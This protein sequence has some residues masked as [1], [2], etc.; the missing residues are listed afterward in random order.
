[1]SEHKFQ[2][3]LWFVAAFRRTKKGG[4]LPLLFFEK[5]ISMEE[6]PIQDADEA[7][8]EACN[9]YG[10]TIGR[11]TKGLSCVAVIVPYYR[12][13]DS[14]KGLAA[15]IRRNLKKAGFT[16]EELPMAA[17]E[18]FKVACDMM[19]FDEAVRR[20]VPDGTFVCLRLQ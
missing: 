6:I 13:A 7:W 19:D 15:R 12:G 2:V 20:R 17:A 3:V 4:T 14:R 1:M 10:E 5:V 8:R 18:F 16:E 9:V 11:C